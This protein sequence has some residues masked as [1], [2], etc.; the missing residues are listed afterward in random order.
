MEQNN[1][2]GK[3]YQIKA[4]SI[5][6][7]G[8]VYQNLQVT[9]EELLHKG[10]QLLNQRA[11]RQAIDV[12]S[13]ATKTNPLISDSHYYLAIALLSGEKPRKIDVWTIERIESELNTAVCGDAKSSKPYMLW[14]IVKHGYYVMN[15]FIEKTPTSAQL[16]SQGQSIETEHAREILFHLVDQK[17]L[18]W[19]YLYNKFGKDN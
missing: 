4:D 3:N 2:G 8:D 10:I 14:A 9:G 12:L 16:F 7:I 5:G 18:Y 11:Y 15:G 1:Y 13:D 17:N 6:H 19:M